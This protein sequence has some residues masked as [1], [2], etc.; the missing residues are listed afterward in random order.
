[1]TNER[2]LKL[3]KRNI[4]KQ[5][6]ETG[7]YKKIHVINFYDRQIGDRIKF[8]NFEEVDALIDRKLGLIEEEIVEV[9]LTDVMDDEE[10]G[11]A[12]LPKEEE[13]VGVSN[14][15]ARESFKKEDEKTRKNLKIEEK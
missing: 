1:M 5:D 11:Y 14:L 12:L 13:E 4:Y 6:P 2:P 8:D 3:V 7:E 15:V 9:D 10:E